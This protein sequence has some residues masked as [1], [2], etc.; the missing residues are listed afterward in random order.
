[1]KISYAQNFEDVILCRALNEISQGFYVDVGAGDPIIDSVT[2]LFYDNNWNGINID[3]LEVNHSKYLDLRPRDINLKLAISDRQ[4]YESLYQS[5]G[6]GGL[7]T[8]DPEVVSGH[9]KDYFVEKQQKIQTTTLNV[10]FERYLEKNEIHFLKI[11]VE[12]YELRVL[13]GLDLKKYRPWIIC[14]ESIDPVSRLANWKTW[15]PLITSSGYV[16][17]YADGLNRFYLALERIKLI[18]HFILPPNIFDNF[19]LHDHHNL[20]N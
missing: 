5:I 1:M 12:G 15:E 20:R 2:K 7:S 10:V 19:V 13:K 3:P 6:A 14:I 11:D 4:E 18:G 16:F 17:T 9:S 8:L